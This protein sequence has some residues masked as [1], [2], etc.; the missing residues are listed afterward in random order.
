MTTYQTLPAEL[1]PLPP[2]PEDPARVTHE[3]L[4]KH[5]GAETPEA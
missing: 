5:G 1:R 3:A 2:S 4:E